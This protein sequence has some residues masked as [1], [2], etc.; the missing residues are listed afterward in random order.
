MRW[1]RLVRRREPAKEIASRHQRSLENCEHPAAA[2]V[3]EYEFLPGGIRRVK[4]L[5]CE[6][7]GAR[8]E[9]DRTD[10]DAERPGGRPSLAA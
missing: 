10:D 6:R 5:H 7:C 3:S 1:L 9:L 4:G 8:V 2:R